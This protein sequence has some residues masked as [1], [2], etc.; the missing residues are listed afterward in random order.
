MAAIASSAIR[1]LFGRVYKGVD[2]T[3]AYVLMSEV[4]KILVRHFGFRKKEI[5]VPVTEDSGVVSLDAQVAWVE[6]ARYVTAP[7]GTPGRVSGNRLEDTSISEENATMG[8]WRK[9]SPGVPQ[10]F[11]QTHGLTGGKLEFDRPAKYSTLIITAATT[12]TPIVAT[13]DVAHGLA[14][15]DRVDIHEG[16]VMTAINGNYYAKVTGYSTTTFA[17]YE[18][19]DLTTPIAGSG[20]YTASSAL[21]V[22][23]NSPALQLFTH[24]HEPQTSGTSLPDTMI[25]KQLYVDGMCW[26]HAK[27]ADREAAP[28]FKELFEDTIAE[29]LPL[30]NGRAG[31]KSPRI[32][33]IEARD[34]GYVRSRW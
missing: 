3:H 25:L 10:A 6:T 20:V 12:A 28:Q 34:E 32:K 33:L 15:G 16:L 17:L 11:M 1:A 18:D 22:C 5:W 24:W 8:D 31:S 9:N 14:D 27:H 4:D 26:L 13:T 2:D 19:E 23:E 30:T 21:V 7:H 29:Q